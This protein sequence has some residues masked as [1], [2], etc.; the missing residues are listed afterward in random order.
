MQCLLAHVMVIVKPADE[1]TNKATFDKIKDKIIP[2]TP[3]TIILFSP[4]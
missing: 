2:I 3:I 4:L 1:E